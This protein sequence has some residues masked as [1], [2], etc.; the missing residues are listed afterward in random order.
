MI[1]K[2]KQFL[3]LGKNDD[4]T[5]KEDRAKE[6]LRDKVAGLS[7]GMEKNRYNG[8]QLFEEWIAADKTGKVIV[9]NE[10]EVEGYE[11]HLEEMVQSFWRN[12]SMIDNEVQQFCKDSWEKSGED[13][14]NYV[15][16]LNWIA[17]DADGV[18]M[19]YWG[20]NV[21][22]ELRAKYS[23]QNEQWTQE[24]IDFQ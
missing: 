16:D 18:E 13:A 19:G 10:I 12:I 20:R 11:E 3:N 6:S 2:I 23:F 22:I 8:K 14:K 21:N 1:E 5:K 9:V 24:E 17:L 15:V 7:L 4:Q